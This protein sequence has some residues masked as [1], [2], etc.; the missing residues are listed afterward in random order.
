MPESVGPKEPEER[1][2]AAAQDPLRSIV[3]GWVWMMSARWS[4]RAIGL[5]S[6]VL[7]ARLLVPKDFGIVAM[8][9]VAVQFIRIFSESGQ[10]LAIIRH[11]DPTPEH[12]D[13][14]WTMSVAS[15]IV[16]ALVLV[17]IAPLAEWYFHEP[18]IVPVI[19][20]LSLAPL[21]EGFTNI[22]AV[23]GFRRS[24]QF[25]KDF[26]F[27]VARKLSTVLVTVPLALVLQNYWALAIGIVCGR[28]VTVLASYLMHPYRPRL[29]FT[30]LKE[31]WAYSAWMQASE[32]G[33]FFGDQTDQIVVG[34]LANA[35]GMG[36]YN[37]G[38]DIASAPTD[39]LVMPAGRA[40]FS[41][42]STLLQDPVRLAEAYLNVLSVMAIIAFSTG[43]GVAIVAS[44]LVTVVL[45]PRWAPAAVLIPWLA[46]GAGL[47]GVARSV[48]AVLSATGNA[49][50]TAI[51][52]WSFAGLL[53]PATVFGGLS[54]GAEGVAAA[55]MIIS[56][57][58]IPAMF[59]TLTRVIPVKSSQVLACVWRPA[60]ATIAMVAAVC[61]SGI[62]DMSSVPLRLLC[63]VWFGAVVF[64]AVLLTLW[65]MSGRPAGG[66]RM[67]LAQAAAVAGRVFGIPKKLAREGSS[68]SEKRAERKVVNDS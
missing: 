12:F 9:M 28:V 45:G 66:E 3:S 27:T 22:G 43:F 8:A 30:K 20:F 61:L 19:R 17:L 32:I 50:L 59:Y 60:L 63:N 44:D 18:R 36:A 40:T 39:E 33:S 52:V 6:T 4:I 55:R 58:F 53:A 68:S 56:L 37:V 29:C 46:I 57:L 62:S 2:A 7:L 65:L 5:L 26:R 31:L 47:L 14:A 24:L 34:G 42:Y 1:R 67:L 15:G 21:I 11:A 16:V 13:T 51:R 10:D 35:A 38:A 54:W 41:V 25:N 49:R 64:F 23:A 48:N